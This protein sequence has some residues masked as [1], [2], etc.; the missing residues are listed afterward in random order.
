MAL[1]EYDFV[2]YEPK[3]MEHLERHLE[4]SETV[5]SH[6]ARGAFPTAKDLIDYACGHIQDY[7]GQR[8]VREVDAGRTL[9]YDSLTSLDG[10]PEQAITSQEPRGKDGYLVNVVRGIEKS[11][12]SQVVVVAGPL[13]EKDKHGFYTIFPGQNAPSFPA[14]REKLEEMGYSGEE[15]ERQTEINEQYE[16]FW[17]SHGFVAED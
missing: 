13:R 14:T 7:A 3:Q 12:T 16:E 6:F 11:P 9:G 15:L 8:L 17:N 5:G 10:L 4:G 2:K 1:K